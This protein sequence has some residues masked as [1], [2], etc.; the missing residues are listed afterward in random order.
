MSMESSDKPHEHWSQSDRI[1]YWAY[2]PGLKTRTVVQIQH[3][4]PLKSKT[5]EHLCP[6]YSINKD[7]GTGEFL[8]IDY[9]SLVQNGGLL[10]SGTKWRTSFTSRSFP[11]LTLSGDPYSPHPCRWDRERK[12]LSS[13]WQNYKFPHLPLSHQ[14]SPSKYLGFLDCVSMQ[15]RY[16]KNFKP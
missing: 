7:L 16:T 11:S 15:M 3:I 10:E 9:W 12:R 8:S 1:V 2:G 13:P 14:N 5:Y 4:G 6:S